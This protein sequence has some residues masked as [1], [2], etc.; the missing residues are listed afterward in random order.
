ALM[1]A[2]GGLTG[3]LCDSLL[4]ATVQQVYY[5]KVRQKITEKK[6]NPLGQPNEPIRGWSWMS[7]DMVNMLSS[8]AGG[9]VATLLFYLVR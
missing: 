1:G 2:V 3:S 8:I 4:G 5:C 7:N 6:L 9:A